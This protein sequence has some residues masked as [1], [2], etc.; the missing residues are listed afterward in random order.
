MFFLF[1]VLQV[2]D[3]YKR[4][5]AHFDKSVFT[6]GWTQCSN[7]EMILVDLDFD[8]SRPIEVESLA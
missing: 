7:M 5:Y 1:A 3:L 4:M 2:R 8:H 6:S